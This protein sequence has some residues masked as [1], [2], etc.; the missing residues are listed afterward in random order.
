MTVKGALMLTWLLSVPV[1][2]CMAIVAWF[3]SLRGALPP[4]R[5]ALGIAGI[6]AIL[7]SWAWFL[8]LAYSGEIGGFGTHYMTTRS[9]DR[10]LI[11][12]L[13]S[14]VASF[15]LKASSRVFAMISSI[16]MTALWCG[17]EMVA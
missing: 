1:L 4:W 9:A 17:S 10:Y 8:R 16:L 6:S 15:S 11:Y 7:G 2:G 5:S 13:V 12:A 14:V 3:R